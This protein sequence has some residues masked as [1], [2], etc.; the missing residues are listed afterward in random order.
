M[1]NKND[2]TGGQ[3]FVTY[4]KLP[5]F[6]VTK[7]QESFSATEYYDLVYHKVKRIGGPLWA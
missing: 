3:L 7:P 6:E 5:E 4:V 1:L 2:V